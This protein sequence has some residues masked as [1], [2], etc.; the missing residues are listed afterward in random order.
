MEVLIDIGFSENEIPPRCRLPRAISHTETVKVKIKEATPEEAPV[1]FVVHSYNSAPLSVR[2]Y[3]NQLYKEAR[4]SY[5]D[6]KQSQV[7]P[8]DET[9]W[10]TELS[11]TRSS[12]EKGLTKAEVM[13][14]LKTRSRQ[15]LIVDRTV[16]VQCYEPYYHITTFGYSGCGTGL[17]IDYSIRSRKVVYGYSALDKDKAIEDAIAIAEG[18]EDQ[19]CIENIKKC[20]QGHIEVLMPVACKRKYKPQK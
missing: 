1:A 9:P 8:F 16:Y 7:Y 12:F 13:A 3:K 17:F 5:Y 6:G 18:R 20:V 14:Y 19:S 4:I 2:L 15:Y 11:P 10:K